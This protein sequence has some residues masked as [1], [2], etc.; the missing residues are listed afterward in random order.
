MTAEH[1][2]QDQLD[3]YEART[4]DSAELLA[5]DRHLATCDQC[6]EKR[7]RKL[8][9]VSE[10]P[11][12]EPFHLDY[13]LLAPYVDGTA[14]EID[15]EIVESHVAL[16]ST[17]AEDLRDLQEFEQQFRQEVEQQEFRYEDVEPWPTRRPETS[18]STG[19]MDLRLWPRLRIAQLTAAIV[20][21]LFL[22]GITAAFLLW[23]GST[24][25]PVHRV[26]PTASPDI[27]NPPNGPS[28][29]PSPGQIANQPSPSPRENQS[30]TLVALNDG[31][32]Q[33]TLDE[34]GHSTGLESLPPDLRANVE[35]VLA[36]RRFNQSP[37]VSDLPLNLNMLRG[38]NEMVDAITLLTPAGVVIE[39]T[40]PTFRWRPL[41]G[42][43]EYV[44]T[45]L[46]SRFRPI[47]SSGPLTGTEWT[48]REPLARGGTYSWQIRATVNGQ[49]VIAPKPP[50]P[51]AR[52]KVLSQKALA[53]IE[54]ARRTQKNYH[55]A[56]AVLY[57]KH[58]LLDAAE[59][60]LE[61]L[62]HANFDSTVASDLLL[63][64]RSLKSP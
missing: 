36:S 10:L 30:P 56:M 3:G 63:S 43:S 29:A 20:I 7:G 53:T 62:K 26:G 57:W 5:V 27:N 23:A 54:N 61:A 47:E 52:F 22:L 13:D 4:L 1:L 44:V 38:G 51:E 21:P 41:Q 28:P 6:H 55:L 40:R 17:C 18:R 46:D 8:P 9:N 35:K 12:D 14:N 34:R 25:P 50:A 45:L 42:A 15:R 31:G 48:I 32:Q 49:T 37:A 39:N 60:E 11:I 59:R 33:I 2:S 58:G 16:C 64:L 24:E 19:W